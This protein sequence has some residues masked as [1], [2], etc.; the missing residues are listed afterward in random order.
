MLSRELLTLFCIE[1]CK[2]EKIIFRGAWKYMK[3]QTIICRQLLLIFF[4]SYHR[5]LFLY[6]L[7]RKMSKRY[8]KDNINAATYK[9]KKRKQVT[10]LSKTNRQCYSQRVMHESVSNKRRKIYISCCVLQLKCRLCMG[11]YIFCR[12]HCMF[13]WS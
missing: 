6:S 8:C 4:Q 13:L 12:P 9:F 2:T 1:R 3:K 5:G 10:F 11:F 7:V